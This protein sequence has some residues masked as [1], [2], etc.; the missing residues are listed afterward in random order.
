VTFTEKEPSSNGSDAIEFMFCANSGEKI[1]P[2]ASSASGGELSRV[3]LAAELAS[4]S[5]KSQTQTV[6]FDEIDSGTGGKAG[7]K[8]GKKLNELSN[9][10]Q[11]FL[12]T[13][14]AQ[15]AAFAKNHI[16][17]YKETKN[18]RVYTKAGIL[19]KNEHIEEIARMVSGQKITKS[20]IEHAKELVDLA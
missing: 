9:K 7:E 19:T 10:K 8:I 1:L 20:A 4:K 16:K 5:K 6:I 12:I 2:L 15:S 11:V 13:H 3:L 17:I 18:S 14:L